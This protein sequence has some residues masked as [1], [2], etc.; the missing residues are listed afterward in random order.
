M[1][2]FDRDAR[3]SDPLDFHLA[4]NRVTL[5]WRQNVLEEAIDWL[6][7]HGYEVVRLNAS[8]WMTE[9]DLHRDF[10]Q[11]LSFPDYYGGNLAALNDCLSDIGTGPSDA[12]GLVLV[13]IGY[14]GFATRH[15]EVAQAALDIIARNAL[16]AMMFGHRM[17]CLVQS[18]D[19]NVEFEPMAAIDVG[20]NRAEWLTDTRD[21]A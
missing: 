16:S 18:A 5:F 17:F 9:A 11:A 15:R 1:A 8:N 7:A 20:W 2:P 13:L 14:D 3:I 4:E 12:T 21:G 19:P 6:L 10:A